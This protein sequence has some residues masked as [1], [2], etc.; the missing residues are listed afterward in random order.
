L[1]FASGPCGV[2]KNRVRCGGA[3]A[4]PSPQQRG[5]IRVP[6]K[7][8]LGKRRFHS[9]RPKSTHPPPQHPW[10]LEPH[11]PRSQLD[12]GRGGGANSLSQWHITPPRPV[13]ARAAAQRAKYARAA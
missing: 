12:S 3:K 4:A 11:T 5:D 2:A 1:Q 10:P 9:Q 13:T 7:V 8:P 6:D